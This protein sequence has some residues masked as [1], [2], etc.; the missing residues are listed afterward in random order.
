M[1]VPRTFPHLHGAAVDA[2][3]ELADAALTAGSVP[4]P[5]HLSLAPVYRRGWG[6]LYAALSKGSL[7]EGVL[8]DLLAGYPPG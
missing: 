3:F 7:D 6:S 2:L 4:S 8:R 5:V 1:G